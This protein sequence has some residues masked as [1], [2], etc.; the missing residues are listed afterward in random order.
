MDALKRAAL[1]AGASSF[2]LVSLILGLAMGHS[3]Q[4][5]SWG[6]VVFVFILVQTAVCVHLW[7]K[8]VRKYVDDAVSRNAIARSAN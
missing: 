2:V 5:E 7:M 6:L 1:A 8:W 3:R 4:T